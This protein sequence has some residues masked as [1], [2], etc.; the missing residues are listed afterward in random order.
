MS[1]A[2]EFYEDFIDGVRVPLFNVI[3]GLNNGWKVAMTTLGH[4]RGGA[5][6]VQHLGFEREFWELV[7][8]ARKY[9]RDTDPLV[10]QQLAWAYTGVQVMRFSGLRTLAQVAEGRPPGPEASVAKLVWS[11]YHKRL[12][13]I[14]IGIVGTDALIRPDGPGYPTSSWQNVFLSSRAGTI[15]SGTSEIQRNIIGERALGLPKEPRGL[16]KEPRGCRRSH[17]SRPMAAADR[18][19]AAPPLPRPACPRTAGTSRRRRSARGRTPQAPRAWRAPLI[20]PERLAEFFAPRSIAVVGASDTSAWARFVLASAAATGFSG[21]L[22]PVHHVRRTVFGLPVV[23]SL[24]DLAEP[25]DLAFV[26]VPTDA[27]ESVLDD[28]GAAGVRGAIVLA[29]GYRETGPEGRAA[30]ERLTARAAAQRDHPARAE[31]PR[32]PQRARQG[33]RRSR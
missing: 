23:A 8:T 33:R 26:L 12:G 6:T 1:G 25:P 17:G 18:G 22:I 20:S 9:G 31:L 27:V 10:R 11:E 2:A 28:A 14:A 24:R 21:E 29:S 16:P 3:G 19:W 15:Y 13:E 4:E 30:E 32:L 5:A 7:E